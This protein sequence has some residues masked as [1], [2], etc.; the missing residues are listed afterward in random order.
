MA[1]QNSLPGT[2][3]I[4]NQKTGDTVIRYSKNADRIVNLTQ[5]SVVRINASPESVNS[6][7]R[8]G[9]DLI[10]HMRDGTTVRY[11]NFFRLDAEGLHSELIFQDEQG[12]HH[13]LFPFATEA[14]PAT[15]E[16][17]VPTFAETSTEALIGAEGVS[18]AAVLGGLA[19]VAGIA[20]IAI[21]AGGSGGNGGGGDNDNNNGGGD[22]GNGDGDGDGDNGGGDNGGG[23]N[24]GGDSGGG[25]NGGGDNGN[26]GGGDGGGNNGNGGGG[27]GGENPLPTDDPPLPST[28]IVDPVTGDNLI[29]A[30]E[31]A[32]DIVISGRTEADN[33][34]ATVTITLGGITYTA[35]VNGDG[36]WSATLPAA[37]LQ[38][39]AD[40]SNPITVTL[41]DANGLPTTQTIDLTV[42][43]TAPTLELTD[44]TPAGVLDEIQAAS[45]KLVR[46]FTS[47]E[48]A[49]QTVTLTLNGQTYTAV[50]NAD[51]SWQTTIPSTALQGLTEGQTYTVGVSLTDAAGNTT[52]AE[53][54]FSVNF[55]VPV[56]TIDPLGGDNALNNAELQLSQIVTGDTQNIPAD[57]LITL[58]LGA[59]VYYARVLGD[60][61][62]SAVIPAA[63]FQALQDGTATLTATALLPDNT[64]VDITSSITIDRA[65]TGIAIAILSTDDN[66]NAAEST[67]PLEVRG[68]TTV[69]GPGVV[70]QVGLNGKIYNAVVDNAGNWSAI[71]PPEDLALLQDGPR[72][73]TAT[74]VLND[75]SAQDVR[76]LNVA[77]NHLPQPVVDTPFG[78]G[79]LSAGEIQQ[80]QIISGNTGVTG[81]GQ[82]VA[83]QV[84]GQNYTAPVD[85]EGNWSIT[86]PAGQ[87]QTLPQGDIPVT[88]VVTDGAGN[89]GS[90]ETTATLD[91]TPPLLSVLPLTSDGKLDAQ[92]LTSTQTLSGVSTEPGQT[93][94][95]TLNNQTYTA[96][97]GDDGRWQ[98]DLPAEALVSLTSGDYPLVASV[99]DAAGNVTETTQIISVKSTQPVVNVNPFTD[100]NI[101]DAAEIK[102]AQTLTGSVTDAAPGSTVSVSFGNWSQS[103]TVDSSG[104][105]SVEVP[106]SV[107]Q[108]LS[109]GANTLQVSV[110]DTF[111]QSATIAYPVTVDTTTDAVAISII[112]ADDYL[113]R[114]EAGSPLLIQGTSAGLPVGTA[115]VVTFNG[116]TY[117]A[118]VDA[119]GNW[120]TE[121]PSAALLAIT[122]DGT[123]T[124]EATAQLPDG[125]VTDLHTLNV[126]INNLPAATSN[127]LFDDGVLSAGET[128]TDQIISGNTGNPG[129]GQTVNVTLGGQVYQGT[130]DSQGNWSVTV[131]SGALSSLTEAQSPVPVQVVVADAAGNTDTLNTQFTVDI[132]PPQ[133]T[134]N[135]FTGDD[136]LNIAEAGAAQ[137]LTGVAA[138]AETGSAIVVTIN[139]VTLN[140]TVTGAG[141]EWSVTV[142]PEVWQGLPNGQ[143]VFNVT[144]TDAAGNSSTTTRTINV[145]ADATQTPLLN[146]DPVT[147]NNIIDAAERAAGITL[148]GTSLNVQVGQ[149]VTITLGAASWTALVDASGNWSVTVP[150]ADLAGLN[151]GSYTLTA[152]VTDAAGNPASQSRDFTVNTDLSS[153]VVAPLTGDDSVGLGEIANGLTISGTTYN[154]AA[155]S[156]LIVTLNGKQYT[157]TVQAD[158]GWSVI[159]PQADAALISDGTVT[160][161]VSTVDAAGNP[162]STTHDFTL[163]TSAL[164]VVTLNT[165]FADG[166]LS[167]AEAAAGGTL[168]GSTGVTGAGQ[169]VVVLIGQT[170]YPATVDASGNWSLALTPAVLQALSDGTLALTITAT[171][172][173]GNQN[174]LQSSLLVDKTAP[175][176]TINDVTADN[177]VNGIEVTQPLQI[178]GTATYDPAN[179]QQVVVQVNGQAYIALVLSDGT[180]S[181]TLPAGA[182]SGAV[183]GPV[184]V[185]ATVTDAAGN[186]TSDTVSFALDASPLNAPALQIDPITGDDYLN[187]A[188]VGVAFTITGTTERVEQGQIVRVTING[189]TY[190]GEVQAGGAWSV[191]IPAAAT[192]GIADGSLPVSV[193]VT[194]AAGNPITVDRPVNIVAQPGSLPQLTVDIVAQDDVI[195]AAERGADLTLSGTSQNL[196]A[197]TPVTVTFN[198]VTYNTTT[199]ANGLWSVLVPSAALAALVDGTTYTVTVNA[200]D[201]AQN[202]ATGTQD[203]LADFTGPAIAINPGSVFDDGLLNVG[204]SA[205]D[206][207]LSGT[208]APGA[209]V[210]VLVNGQPITTAVVANEQGEWTLAI[211]AAQLQALSG[212]D[213]VLTVQATD[214]QGNVSTSPITVDVGNDVLPTLAFNPVSVDNV[215]NGPEASD[216]I[217]ITGTSTGLAVGTPVTLTIG[218]QTYTGSV[219]AENVWSVEVGAGG[220]ALLSALGSGQ[221]TATVS[222]ADAYANPATN[223]VTLE[224]VLATPAATLPATIFTDDFLNAAEAGAGQTLNGSTGLAG[225][226]QTV[227][228]SID[229]GAPIVGTVD[230]TGAWSVALT[231]EVL[232]ALA[233]GTHSLTVTVADRAGN[234]ATS[235]PETFTSF[236][237]PLPTPALTAPLFGD[238][239]LT[240]AETTGDYTFTI[241]TGVTDPNRPL[242]V[243]ATLNN[244]TPITATSNGDGTWSVTIPAGQLAALPD[245]EIPVNI[246]VTDAAGN[247]NSLAETVTAVINNV[248]DVTVNPLFGDQVLTNAEANAPAGQVITGNTGATGEG[249]TVTV[250][251]TVNAFTWTGTAQTAANG[252]WTVTIPTEVLASLPSG[253]TPAI[254]VTA[255][256][257]AGNIDTSDPVTFAVETTLPTPTVDPLFGGDNILNLAEAASD[258]TISGSTGVTGPNQYVTV[259]LNINGIAYVAS[260]ENDGSWSVALPAGSLQNLASGTQVPVSVTAQDQYGNSTTL[261]PAPS[262]LVAFTPP[263]ATLDPATNSALADGYLTVAEADGALTFSGVY[264]TPVNT[265]GTQIT[266]TIGGREFPAVVD[267]ASST[268]SV[269]LAPGALNG[270]ASGPQNIT[271]NI[272]D[273]A[274]NTGVG[275]TPV[276]VAF[277]TPTITVATP[278]GDGQLDWVESQ[279]GQTITGTTTNVQVGQTVTVTL[280]GQVF[281]TT[282]QPGG[283]WALALT[284]AQLATLNP[285]DGTLTATVTDVAGNTATSPTLTVTYDLTPP[286][287]SVNIDP[288]TSDG[289]LNAAELS[290]GVVTITGRTTDLAGQTLTLSLNG[291]AIG[292]V[293]INADGTW[294]VPVA[295]SAFPAQGDYT[296]TAS[297]VSPAP[298]GDPFTA[299]STLAV[300]TVAPQG[301]GIN[302]LAGDDVLSTSETGAPLVISGQVNAAEAGRPVTVNLNGVNYY[303]TVNPDGTWSTT[304]PQSAVDGLTSGNYVVT[305]TVT[306]AAGNPATVERPLTVDVD[307]P[308]L[309]VD[310]LSVPAVLNTVNA[311]GGLLLQGTGE[312]GQTV[313]IGLGPL[314]STA[315]VDQNGNWT[316]TF[317]QLDLATLTDGAQVIQISSTDANGNTSTNRVALNVALNQ[318]LGV[319]VDDLFGGDG[320]LNVAESLVTQV[321]TGRV[322]GDYRGATVTA[323]VIGTD[324]NIPLAPV[325][326]GDGSFTIDLPP[327][328]WQGLIDQTLQ[329]NVGVT[330]AFGNTTNELIDFNLALSDL[331]IVGN[332]LVGLD[333]IINLNDL[334]GGAGQVVSG[335]LSNAADVTSVVVNVAGQTLNAVVDAA[336]GTWTTT[337]P[338]ALLSALPS[339]STGLQVQVTD[340]AGNVLNTGASFTLANVAPTISLAPLFGNGILSVPELVNGVISGTAT[341]LNG[342]NLTVQIGNTQAINVVVGPDG[343]WSANLPAAVQSALQALGSGNV[344]V[345]VTAADQY[346]NGATAGANLTLSLLQPVLNTVALFTDNLLNAADALVSQT[347]SGSV[348]QAAA[349]SLVS[350]QLGNQTFNGTVGANGLFSIQVSPSQL[351]NLTDGSLT[352]LI[353]I[354]TPEGNSTTAP[355]PVVNVGIGTLPTVAITSLLGGADGFLN[356]A[357]AAAGQVIS[358][359]TNLASGTVRVLVNGTELLAPVVNGVWSVAAPASLLQGLANGT[360]TVTAQAVDAVG[361]VASSGTQVVNALIQNLPQLALNPLFGDNTLSLSDLLNPQVLSGTATNLA[362]GTQINVALGPLNLTTTVAA[363]GT[364]RVPVAT[365]LLQGL[366][367]GLLN[368]SVTAVDKAGNP[369]TATGGLNVSI[370]ALPSI[371]I[372]SIFGDNGLNVADLLNAQVITGT[373]TNAVGS[374]VNVT[375]GGKN[376]T[377]TVGSDGNWQVTVPKTDLGGLLDGTLAVNASV[378]N[379]AGNSTS[380]SG[381]L[382][383]I[384]H[385]LPSI[386]LTSLFGNDKYLNVSEAASGQVL[387]GKIS[388]AADG[389]SVV[390]NLGGNNYN[391]AVNPDGTWSLPVASSVLQ[392]LTNGALKVGVTVTDK[393]GNTNTSSADVTVK[394]TTPTLTFNPLATL[395][396][397]TLLTSGLTLRG[398]S[399]NLGAG[400]VVHLSLLNGT[401][402]TTAITDANGNWSANL[403]LGLNILQILSLSSVLNIYAA[404]AA[405]NIGYLN[406]GLGGQII[407][408]TPPAGFTTLSA[409]SEAATFSL[410]SASEEHNSALAGDEQQTGAQTL[411]ASEVRDDT[412]SSA[413]A[414]TDSS[415]AAASTVDG[416]YTIGGVSIDLADGTSLSGDTVQGSA[417]NDTIHLASLG[418]TQI[419][420][421]AGTDTL[422][423]DGV[424]L[425]LNLTELAGKLQHIEI[426]DLGKSGTNGLTLDVNQ[427]LTVTDKP[428]DDLVVKG[429]AGDQVNLINGAGDVWE[430]SGQREMDGV[431]FDVYHNSSQANTLGDVLIQQGIHVNHV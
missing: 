243:T 390:V 297:V 219:T 304:V 125:T 162:L 421:G 413:A 165:P 5:T 76:T 418:F 205:V 127:P 197:G 239:V 92:E 281:T 426:V 126:L 77:I 417:G 210:I 90:T 321:L 176:L 209:S 331:P 51:G 318:G 245:G 33:A 155:D 397:L 329:L 105:W 372:N 359:T 128:T 431:Q 61:S 154:V 296:L 276:T 292:T 380:T 13:A 391:A 34:G 140:G 410:L 85:N 226:G 67:Q 181:V 285:A 302:V 415:A 326:A 145:A 357:E 143:A 335:T 198:N 99:T 184:A 315:T 334:A 341:G 221:F 82:T 18:T 272:T 183:D 63:D 227:S 161:A 74:V 416:A 246:V 68:I 48:E 427:A 237:T 374:L 147:A 328:L 251:L 144:A 395:N 275:I 136:Y 206:Q 21:A 274:G 95:V 220:S 294:A 202:P 307:A 241:N 316:Y 195:N 80:D 118:T 84:G 211:P 270:I 146:I 255:Q 228:V 159:V 322:S 259:T 120:Q 8:Q 36:T 412:Q 356:A 419:D 56:V 280:S 247:A 97:V 156:Q 139:G 234:T 79:L 193:T 130:V 101:L 158:G 54:S 399:S 268:W 64:T 102:T 286:A 57:S 330:D 361:N 337:L 203:V 62:W 398:G 343:S 400:S 40:G 375:L 405:G 6:Y 1:V 384:T 112:S 346:G 423:L 347:I 348:G 283:T 173:A 108:A 370:G 354:T 124:V 28:L 420:G 236:V 249:Q 49:G 132:T 366:T 29:N 78:D 115:V 142:P 187:A 350:V 69:S 402:S 123:Y 238:D 15:A 186:S 424:N 191:E 401:V 389:A 317:P 240:V 385:S 214:T 103:V 295:S 229:G 369:A 351:A 169:T 109:E 180:W 9:N 325:L 100:D 73:I 381:L 387:S 50:V 148:S 308:L 386:S 60:G 172:G 371:A 367:D 89:I 233:D 248:P 188:E 323:S 93:V 22:N 382:N 194:D 3:D 408:T 160:F 396:P 121:I 113:N 23:D 339:G 403:G 254:T 166:I 150:P 288:V 267:V 110:T 257:A 291:Q 168:N 336:T 12:V 352:S 65:Q 116:A 222:A 217:L 39:L 212:D 250:T 7:E 129:A 164:P 287:F 345:S 152:T 422:V 16:A 117:N 35:I 174:V 200:T 310:A 70:V 364:W 149:Q 406:V 66:L 58:T 72:E 277:E 262:F 182:L 91:T 83:V 137:T 289:V 368:V 19:A 96:V 362:A 218:G 388:G 94:T 111:N 379:P 189:Q 231:P 393:V 44:F 365:N 141:G 261:D 32:Q 312:P 31:R 45:D 11:Q 171:D 25:D 178:T 299:T 75:Q 98:I 179:P 378:V 52:T 235:A 20:G 14:G 41:V 319:L 10:V 204:E 131:P 409:E 411:L 392:G 2:V 175:A 355:G 104:N 349:G 293:T 24:G 313:T 373:S 190:E 208:T 4:L 59:R 342:Q 71:I 404:D 340:T 333:N 185:T 363:D 394:L 279:Q 253:T 27:D 305:A 284:P 271:V 201:A 230:N 414:A 135:P 256:D 151:S 301:L 425:L 377:T 122:T 258:T 81:S 344:A 114:T 282:V 223:S 332:V 26:G 244:G 300:D 163:I 407:S 311:A 429:G 306:D 37:A 167:A 153:V 196:A 225:P 303:T 213:V 324:V 30:Q 133:I 207:V 170:E 47:A 17:I 309:T 224:L 199:D 157:A 428:E 360:V 107:L 314:S 46:G 264:T 430:I 216:V 353:T 278:F 290:G 298:G 383:V 263:T 192:A 215:I 106:V 376:Y 55:T 119:N 86:V 87:L 242:T 138:G 177:I 273:G 260:V 338:N 269:T 266:V 327:S 265:E 42:D 38:A 43:A 134:V 320:I 252:D 232:A 88:V 53:Q 358:G